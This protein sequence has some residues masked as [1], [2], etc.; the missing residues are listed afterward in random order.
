M[1]TAKA[2]ARTSARRGCAAAGDWTGRDRSTGESE[3][4]GVGLAAS[5]LLRSRCVEYAEEEWR[6]RADAYIHGRARVSEPVSLHEWEYFLFRGGGKRF[7]AIGLVPVETPPVRSPF[8][9]PVA[10]R[11]HASVNT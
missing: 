8:R 9:H 3:G 10:Q 1:K 11:S 5:A 7:L 4:E 6:G 2:R